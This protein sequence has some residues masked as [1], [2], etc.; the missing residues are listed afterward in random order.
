M[1][2]FRIITNKIV[3]VCFLAFGVIGSALSYSPNNADVIKRLE[4]LNT[5]IDVQIT[6][7][8]IQQVFTLIE[9]RKGDASLILGRASLYFPVIENALREKG[10][11]DELKYIAIIE[12]SLLPNVQSGQGASGMWQFMKGTAELYGLRVD[13]YVD[14]RKD[15]IKST[16][17]ALNYLQLLFETYGDWNLALAAYNC[18]PGGVNKAIK[19]A[20][21][22]KDYWVIS[23]YL[24]TETRRYVPRFLAA[25]Y[26]MNFY[27]IHDISPTP[28]SDDILYAISVKVT[29]KIDFKKLS[30]EFDIDIDLIRFLNPTFRKDQIPVNREEGYVLN[31][32]DQIMYSYIEKYNNLS[33]IVENQVSI[34]RYASLA[35]AELPKDKQIVATEMVAVLKSQNF[36]ARDNLKDSSM[37]LQLRENIKIANNPLILYKLKKKESL[38][39]VAEAKNISFEDLLAI[40]NIKISDGL[41]PGSIIRLPN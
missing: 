36:E 24:P 12:S 21:G 37:L 11:P 34:S 22:V 15:F 13:K 33:N 17:K 5:I 28:I 10:L 40:N 26:L 9:K 23:K 14:E 35:N 38:M 41:A 25:A 1:N 18:G 29:D 8:V 19:K 27:D 20:G 39:D 6:E 3:M 2:T 32:P 30:K 31:L 16:D 4:N 7:D